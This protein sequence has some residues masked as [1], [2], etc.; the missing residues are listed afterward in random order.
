MATLSDGDAEAWL[1]PSEN[2]ARPLLPD[3]IRRRWLR[4]HLAAMGLEWASFQVMRRSCA[5]LLKAAGVAAHTRAAILGHTVDVEEN[6]YA[7]VSFE[8]KLRAIETLKMQ[9]SQKKTGRRRRRSETKT[10]EDLEQV[11]R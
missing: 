1:F 7:Q 5:T 10:E 3:N 8:E 4:P 9:N 2:P 6:E 11:R